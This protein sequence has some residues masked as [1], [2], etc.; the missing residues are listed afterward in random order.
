MGN[1]YFSTFPPWP[2]LLLILQHFQETIKLEELLDNSNETEEVVS[3]EKLAVCKKQ[4]FSILGRQFKLI[5]FSSRDVVQNMI[6]KRFNIKLK[7]SNSGV[8]YG[9]GQYMGWHTDAPGHRLYVVYS[10]EVQKSFFRYE[11]PESME[12][13][14]VYDPKGWSLRCFHADRKFWHCAYSG[15]FRYAVGWSANKSLAELNVL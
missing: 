1:Y 15:T 5:N 11:N 8:G 2:E 12:I 13:V 10:K 4:S 3:A 14:T 7:Q 6:E 9:P